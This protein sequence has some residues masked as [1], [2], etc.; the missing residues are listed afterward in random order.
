[1]LSLCEICLRGKEDSDSVRGK[2]ACI[3][4][5]LVSGRS[6]AQARYP[7]SDDGCYIAITCSPPCAKSGPSNLWLIK[8]VGP[9]G[10]RSRQDG[11]SPGLFSLIHCPGVVT[12]T[13]RALYG[14][15]DGWAEV[16]IQPGVTYLCTSLAQ[17]VPSSLFHSYFLPHLQ[18]NRY[19]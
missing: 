17:M 18:Q 14:S 10:G 6:P 19:Y 1:M 13:L 3:L 7:T 4:R 2:T 15:L 11:V 16:L 5:S 8:C 12:R 9:R